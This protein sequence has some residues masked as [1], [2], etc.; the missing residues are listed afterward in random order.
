M[1]YIYDTAK[2]KFSRACP[3][4]AQVT[5]EVGCLLSKTE[6]KVDFPCNSATTNADLDVRKP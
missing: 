5:L 2:L 6:G 4:G 3:A 1:R